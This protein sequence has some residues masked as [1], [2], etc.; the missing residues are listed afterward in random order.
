M[1]QED[2]DAPVKTGGRHYYGDTVRL[3]FMVAAAVMALM[4]PFLNQC[5][6]V[7][8]PLSLLSIVIIGVMA[9]LIN[10]R[11]SSLALVNWGIS[12]IALIVFEYHAV[13]A[14]RDYGWDS[15]IFATN[16]F[17]AVLFLIALYFSSKTL[18]G[19]WLKKESEIKL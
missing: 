16:Q 15:L 12:I 3:L 1:F 13:I 18:R 11:H 19:F 4:L 17:L 8:V 5:L 14:Y 6:S 7:P 10:P 9:G 2:S